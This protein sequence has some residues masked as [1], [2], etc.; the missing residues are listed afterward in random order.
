[1]RSGISI[2]PFFDIAFSVMTPFSN[3]L[4]L[5]WQRWLPGISGL[6][7]PQS[8]Q[9]Q[10]SDSFLVAQ[11]SLKYLI[12]LSSV[13]CLFQPSYYDWSNSENGWSGLVQGLTLKSWEEA[14]FTRT[15][16]SR[17]M[18]VKGNTKH[19]KTCPLYCSETCLW[20]A[21]KREIRRPHWLKWWCKKKAE[22]EFRNK[23]ERE[24]TEGVYCWQCGPVLPQG[25][26]K[27]FQSLEGRQRDH[28]W[29]HPKE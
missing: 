11:V 19:R 13:T 14:S 7:H 9:S 24:K 4:S 21:Q 1:M 26:G 25:E 10:E 5:L 20:W 18:G 23:K 6:G 28:A 22:V 16:G 3:K 17:R 27:D 8:L 15:H 12:D 29:S 2:S